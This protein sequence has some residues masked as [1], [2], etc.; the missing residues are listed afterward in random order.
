MDQQQSAK[1]TLKGRLWRYF[2]DNWRQFSLG[3]AFLLTTQFLAL[4]IPRELGRAIQLLKDGGADIDQVRSQ[5]IGHAIAI[6]VLALLAAGTR[7]LSRIQ[8]FSAGRTIEY[9]L[10]GQVFRHLSRLSPSYYQGI[11]TG[12]LTSR[13]INDTTYVRLL[14]GLGILHSTNTVFAYSLAVGHMVR[15]D[16]QLAVI[17]LLPFPF[18]LFAVQKLARALH[19]RTRV[20]QEKLADLSAAVQE[21]LSGIAVIKAYT[22]EE[23]ETRRFGEKCEAYV[24]ENLKLARI[25]TLLMPVMQSVGGLGAILVLYFGGRAVIESGSLS[26]GEFIEFSGY[27]GLLTWPTL[28][29]GWVISVWQRGTAAFER[30]TQVLDTEPTITAPAPS[31]EHGPIRTGRIEF[32]DVGFRYQAD[33]A[34]V[35]DNVSFTIQ[36]GSKVGIVG[37]S[38]SGKTSLVNLIARLYDPSEG[39]IRIDDRPLASIPLSHLRE[40]IGYAPQE[41]F[42]FSTTVAKNISFG[43]DGSNSRADETELDRDLT[44]AVEASQISRDISALPSG[45]ETMVGERGITLSGGQK[46]RVALA[47][48][49]MKEPTILILDDSL[50]S[51][52]AHTEQLILGHLERAMGSSTAIVVTHR[53]NILE[54][55]DEVL[56]LEHGQVIERGS[57]ATLMEVQG[58]YARMVE[59]QRIKEELSAL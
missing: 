16:W 40:A 52:D 35:L 53:F 59:R 56:V 47:R 57:H 8:V 30:I 10:R 37:K 49:L 43:Y 42:L 18:I 28:A 45:L 19:T 4:R 29:L 13:V 34:P 1:P 58:A 5:V 51:V 22:A 50:S 12:D 41:P 21:D 6:I 11:P 9:D 24:Q 3:A 46:Q 44:A 20:V 23:S 55:M 7:V 38:G 32:R 14:F 33:G 31:Q 36:S 17:V 26:L 27:V 25:R 54:L 2:T 48:A 15:L 39:E